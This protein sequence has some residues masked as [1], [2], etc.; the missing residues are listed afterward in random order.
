MASLRV[1]KKRF[2]R[3]LG[4]MKKRTR[5]IR[6]HHWYWMH[7]GHEA[8]YFYEPPELPHDRGAWGSGPWQDEP[9]RVC[10]ERNGIR[11]LIKRVSTGA[12]CGYVSI[13]PDHPARKREGLWPA[14]ECFEVHGG[15]T[16]AK[17]LGRDYWIG[18]DCGHA[19][20]YMPGHATFMRSLGI[21]WP[22][23][24]VRYRD[25]SYVRAE[26]ERLADQVIASLPS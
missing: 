7:R 10:F 16:F 12:L 3:E 18:F 14:N 4:L 20:D 21:D 6:G 22:G 8:L 17:R 26:V 5:Q 15:V 2:A 13:P 11:C 19:G 24:G 9:D 23:E 25:L 1:R